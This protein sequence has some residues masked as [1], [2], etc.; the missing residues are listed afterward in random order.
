MT[1]LTPDEREVFVARISGEALKG[2]AARMGK[3]IGTVSTHQ[4][5]AVRKLL[6]DTNRLRGTRRLRA[7]RR[8]WE[9]LLRDEAVRAATEPELRHP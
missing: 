4:D 1:E 2:I 8:A 7:A 9:R 3:H 6:G 5:R